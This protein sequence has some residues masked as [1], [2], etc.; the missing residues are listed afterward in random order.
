MRK[1]TRY[2]FLGIVLSLMS[3]A[4]A[5]SGKAG[6]V[7]VPY[8]VTG[9]AVAGAGFV[10]LYGPG[11]VMEGGEKEKYDKHDYVVI[12]I[13][14]ISALISQKGISGGCIVH[15]STLGRSE[16]IEVTRQRCADV[17]TV[18]NSAVVLSE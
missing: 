13:R 5:G 16:Q 15:Y 11:K 2:L 12:S 8:E 3:I 6:K 17:M 7:N 14:Y 9:V 10:R 18:I 1:L 4:H